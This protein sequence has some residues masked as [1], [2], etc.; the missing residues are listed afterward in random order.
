MYEILPRSDGAV[1]GVKVS[2]TLTIEE[3]K[4]LIAKADELVSTYGKASFL[5]VLGDHVGVSLKAVASDIKWVMTH[6]DK[7]ARVAVVTDSKFVSALVDIDATFA[8]LAG[9]KEKHFA[10]AELDAAWDWIEETMPTP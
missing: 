2:G 3:E 5:V 6:M 1:L 4:E 9:I 8:N 10:T 7:I